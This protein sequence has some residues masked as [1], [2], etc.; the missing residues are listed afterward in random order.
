MLDSNSGGFRT[1]PYSSPPAMA[2]TTRPKLPPGPSYIVNQI[3]S[4]K[5][6]ACASSIALI[7]VAAD[8]AGVYVPV[9]AIITSSAVALPVVLF[10]QSELRYWRDR[11][12][13]ETL[14]ARLARKV[15]GRKPFGMDL[16]ASFLET[17][18]SGYIGESS[19]FHC[20]LSRS[21]P[22]LGLGDEVTGWT[23]EFG[24]T[25]DLYYLGTSHVGLIYFGY[26][27][28]SR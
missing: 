2:N 16:I 22:R 17:H 19:I 7:R 10:I 5:T 12:T 15:T 21:V 14:G 24:Q 1:A 18:E 8:V 4:W 9:W 11:R 13:A 3:L 26:H 25:I 20:L 6:A 27:R 23:T 28:R